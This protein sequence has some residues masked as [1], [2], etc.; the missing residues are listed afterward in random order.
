MDPREH[1]PV[2]L[3][4]SMQALGVRADGVYVDAT[5]GRGGHAR[6]IL[7]RLGAGG[8]LL[9]VDRD[10]DAV[11]AGAALAAADPRL[12][13]RRARFGELPALVQQAGLAGR[14]NGLLADLG[15]SSPQLDSPARG[16][17]F[18]ADGPL[19]MRMDP[20]VGVS[21]ADW[22][23]DAA[24]RDIARVLKVYGEER[25]AK[26]IARAICTARE[27]EPLTTTRQ[28][29]ALC[30]R[31]VPTR[32][33]GKHPAT[34]TFQ[35]LRIQVNAELEELKALLAG[36]CDLLAAGGRLVVISF[37]S[38]EDR[39]VKRFIR[40][41]SRGAALPKGLPV[42][43]DQVPRRLKPIDGAVR[44]AEGEVRANPRA[45]SAVLRAAERL[46]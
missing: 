27:Q 39:I 7:G 30:E 45:R 20:D 2:L 3:G 9:A 6:A 36:A 25:F 8:R 18:S 26:R 44:A 4:E 28:L 37:H 14:V 40:D 34:R 1:I 32:E 33:P 43:D 31:A 17:S 19:D 41:E 11:A 46:A 29:A 15:V 10:P 12:T 5:F 23:A 13:L 24:E 42:T 38:L 21:A 16:F 35:A 22:L